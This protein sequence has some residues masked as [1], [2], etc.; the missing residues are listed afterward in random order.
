[1]SSF[2]GTKFEGFFFFP[3]FQVS[4]Q[5]QV[6]LGATHYFPCIMA[7]ERASEL[8]TSLIY[9]RFGPTQHFIAITI[10]QGDYNVM[11]FQNEPRK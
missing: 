2:Q 10:K 9:S 11:N 8:I 7:P 5:H 4:N 1:M 6:Q 3:P